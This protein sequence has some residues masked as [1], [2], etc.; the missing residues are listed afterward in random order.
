MPRKS[1]AKVEPLTG[2]AQQAEQQPQQ[3]TE[4][5]DVLDDVL[6]AD[7]P[8]ADGWRNGKP[9]RSGMKIE[10]EPHPGAEIEEAL[11][12]FEHSRAR[13]ASKSGQQNKQRGAGA[14]LVATIN[15]IAKLLPITKDWHPDKA[16]PLIAAITLHKDE[17][18]RMAALDAL[19]ALSNALHGIHVLQRLT[20]L[21]AE[22]HLQQQ[23]G[24]TKD[25]AL[26]Q[27][28]NRLAARFE[29]DTGKDANIINDGI[30]GEMRGAF[31]TYAME[32][33]SYLSGNIAPTEAQI[34]NCTRDRRK[35]IKAAQREE[36]QRKEEALKAETG[37]SKG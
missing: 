3:P 27:L 35:K 34:A 2:N 1:R 18:E 12:L 5:P 37:T 31:L 19:T 10:R 23:R 4:Q 20:A 21:A 32:A 17:S 30:T 6:S 24:P 7:G 26:Q 13:E 15:T 36:E 25:V 29:E 14:E 8:I 33:V 16:A 28:V 9:W 22:Q 11:R